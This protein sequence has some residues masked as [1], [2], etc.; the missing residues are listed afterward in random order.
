M[1]VQ[2]GYMARRLSYVQRRQLLLLHSKSSLIFQKTNDRLTAIHQ[3]GR[4]GTCTHSNRVGFAIFG[5]FVRFM[6]TQRAQIQPVF[7]NK[8]ITCCVKYVKITLAESTYSS[9]LEV[10][11]EQGLTVLQAIGVKKLNR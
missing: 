8:Q 3:A 9:W 10:T 6:E 1:D 2:R 11:A 7:K 4:P 5:Q